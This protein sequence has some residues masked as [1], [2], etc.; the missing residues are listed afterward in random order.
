M[1]LAVSVFAGADVVRGSPASVRDLQLSDRGGWAG[2]DLGGVS[3]V[4]ARQS[5]SSAEMPFWR[6]AR[7]STAD[8]RCARSVSLERLRYARRCRMQDHV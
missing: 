4:A 7:G 5:S 6:V 2:G 1:R 3:L 8:V